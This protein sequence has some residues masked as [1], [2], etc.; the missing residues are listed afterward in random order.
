MGESRY[1]RAERRARR[2]RRALRATLEVF[3]GRV[4]FIFDAAMGKRLARVRQHM[5]LSQKQMARHLG[6]SQAMLCRA[7]LGKVTFLP[8]TA[9]QFIDALPEYYHFV[10]F[11]GFR[12]WRKHEKGSKNKKLRPKVILV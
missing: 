11:G 1:T 8:L 12:L 10:L 2:I 4:S 7:E 3:L 5:E 6:I 9:G